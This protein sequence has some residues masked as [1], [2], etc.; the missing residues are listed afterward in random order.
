MDFDLLKYFFII[1]PELLILGYIVL[2]I[3]EKKIAGH[4]KEMLPSLLLLSLLHFSRF[5]IIYTAAHILVINTV[6]F[7]TIMMIETSLGKDQSKGVRTYLILFLF[8]LIV[9]ITINYLIDVFLKVQDPDVF[10]N[11]YSFWFY[12]PFY[13]LLKGCMKQLLHK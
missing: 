2:N 3:N 5:F 13:L 8:T 1:I 11:F 9:K 6:I 7:L 12:L 10:E 4:T